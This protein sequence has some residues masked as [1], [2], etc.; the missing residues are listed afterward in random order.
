MRREALILIARLYLFVREIGGA[1]R[2]VWVGLFQAYTGNK[3]GDSW[4]ASFVCFCLSIAYQGNSPLEK[5]ASCDEL[6]R[7]CR[8][9]GYMVPDPLPGDLVFNMAGKDDA[10]HIAI[11]T[12]ALPYTLVTIAGNTSEDGKSSNGDGVY[13]HPVSRSNKVYARLP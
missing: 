12:V 1:N 11:A 7:Q 5:S 10:V 3:A 4:C 2:G 13:E 8:E 9:K 6:L